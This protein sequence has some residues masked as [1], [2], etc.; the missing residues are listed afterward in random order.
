MYFDTFI[1]MVNQ[2][3]A[4]TVG[5]ELYITVL[6][7]VANIVKEKFFFHFDKVRHNMEVS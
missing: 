5:T 3:Y 7:L 2:N 1:I 4:K 6:L